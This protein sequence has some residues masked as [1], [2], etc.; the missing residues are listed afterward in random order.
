MLNHSRKNSLITGYKKKEKGL[1]VEVTFQ[2][3][4]KSYFIVD[5]KEKKEE[6][7]KSKI[8]KEIYSYLGSVKTMENMN[9]IKDNIESRKKEN[10]YLLILATIMGSLLFTC[11]K[12]N[13]FSHYLL[14]DMAMLVGG[15]SSL[16]LIAENI[17]EARKE[18]SLINDYI[19]YA[20]YF[21]NKE[22]LQEVVNQKDILE[23]LSKKT[24]KLINENKNLDYSI[25]GKI[26]IEELR[27]ID[28]L[29]RIKKEIVQGKEQNFSNKDNKTDEDMQDAMKIIEN[30]KKEFRIPPMADYQSEDEE[31]IEDIYVGKSLTRKK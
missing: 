12:L 4:E 1:E 16:V 28:N 15:I 13:I 2:N 9:K 11:L 29:I 24:Q 14:T 23:N 7:V 26:N 20:F 19:K 22:I 18:K 8:E 17:K 3:G 5:D 21:N 27:K 30:V 25:I 6:D 31:L 10:K